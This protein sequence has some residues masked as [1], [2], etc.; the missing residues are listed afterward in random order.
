MTVILRR[1]SIQARFT[2]AVASL[3]LVAFAVIGVGLDVGL[4]A[5]LIWAGESHIVYAGTIRPRTLSIGWTELLIAVAVLLATA[6]AAWVTW[7]M[8]GRALRPVAAIRARMSEITVSDLSMRVPEPSCDD[9]IGRLARTANQTLARLEEAVEQQRRF[10]YLVSHELKTPVAG[11]RAQ[12]EEALLYPG[13]IDPRETLSVAVCATERLRALIEDMLVFARIR[14]DASVGPERLDL[15]P[16][17]RQEIA[18]TR[19]GVPVRLCA[20]GGTTVEGNRLQMVQLLTNLLDN[21]RRHAASH[22]EVSVGRDGDQAVLVVTDDGEGIRPQDREQVFDPFVRLADA[23]S[24]DPGGTGLGLAICRTIVAAH[25][26]TLTVEDAPRGARFVA[27]I[28]LSLPPA[29]RRPGPS[30]PLL[31]GAA[32]TA[33]PDE[34]RGFQGR[35]RTPQTSE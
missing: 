22:V 26:G 16:L 11:M 17:V 2:A 32:V 3:M 6:F 21:A 7:I 28:P 23:R 34:R 27:R 14:T 13:Q 29:C 35:N 15:G 4:H 18:G 9:E 20:E 10:A 1:C 31:R 5:R 30:D 19:S 25:H 12:M 33:S 24:R 8:A